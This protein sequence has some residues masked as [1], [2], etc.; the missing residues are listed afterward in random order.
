MASNYGI[1]ICAVAAPQ[2]LSASRGVLALQG[3]GL[4]GVEIQGSRRRHALLTVPA[5]M[6]DKPNGGWR[7]VAET[8]GAENPGGFPVFDTHA[9]R[10]H[11][12]NVIRTRHTC[13]TR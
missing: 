11:P 9:L 1:S 13:R 7:P 10:V 12:A 5:A 2:L 6:Q 4:S 8:T 3:T